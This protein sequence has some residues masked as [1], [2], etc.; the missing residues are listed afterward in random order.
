M[1]TAYELAMERLEKESPRLQ[2]PL[3][4]DQKK[5]L[6]EIDEQYQAK[7]AE[8]RILSEKQV[9]DLLREGKQEEAGKA[10]E[11]FI[12]EMRKLEEE[13]ESEKEKVRRESQ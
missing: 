1:K 10:R 4:D 5:R 7:I 6:A 12:E 8:R 3:T 9:M 11:Q 2:K 13:K